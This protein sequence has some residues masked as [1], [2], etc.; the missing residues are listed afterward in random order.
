LL[1]E[2]W[3][4]LGQVKSKW[5][6]LDLAWQKAHPKNNDAEGSA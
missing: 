1:D 2:E 3:L 4:D 5:L 6:E